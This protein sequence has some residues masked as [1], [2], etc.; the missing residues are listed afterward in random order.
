MMNNVA[1]VTCFECMKLYSHFSAFKYSKYGYCWRWEWKGMVT[2]S[3]WRTLIRLPRDVIS[4]LN[5]GFQW[6]LAQIFIMYVGTD[7][8]LSWTSIFL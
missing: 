6:N 4:V 8:K 7:E 2:I 3:H 1:G 5:E